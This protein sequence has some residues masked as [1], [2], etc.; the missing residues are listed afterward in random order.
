VSYLTHSDGTRFYYKDLGAGPTVLLAH[1]WALDSSMW[2]YQIPVLVAAGYR[3]V[4]MDRRGHGRTDEPGTGY[5]LDTLA[6]DLADLVNHLDLTEVAVLAHSMA[7]AEVT[8]YLTRHGSARVTRAAFVGSVTPFLRGAVGEASYEE[9]LAE[10]AADRPAWFDAGKD[11]YFAVPGSGVSPPLVADAVATI[12]RSPLEVLLA[13]QRAGTGTDVSAELAALD[14]PVLV[15]HGDIDASA[16][17]EVTGRPTA[18]LIPDS[19]LVVYPG[20]PHGLYLTHR[21]R[22]NEELLD[23]LAG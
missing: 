10:F 11:A 14:V 9:L 18:E 7:C 5:D 22:L 15:V 1:S 20:G 13:C 19:R 4:A 23:W 17:L 12:L 3:C 2:E 6:D 21:D 16:P 8:R